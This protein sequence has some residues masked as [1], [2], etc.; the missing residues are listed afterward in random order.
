MAKQTT[1]TM[2]DD[3]DGSEAEH[4]IE[5]GLD[6][7]TFE[8][9]LSSENYAKL[10]ELF[11]PFTSVARF[12]GRPGAKAAR[13]GVKTYGSNQDRQ[14]NQAIR[15]WARDNNVEIA[16]RGRIPAE[17]I[18]AYGNRNK[19]A[20]QVQAETEAKAE[21]AA[22]EAAKPKRKS[23]IRAAKAKVDAAIGDTEVVTE[24]PEQVNGNTVTKLPTDPKSIRGWA[25][26][27]G[28]KVSKQGKIPASVVE[29]FEK[30]H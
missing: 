14:Q 18:D 7:K 4:S 16:E 10:R 9:D 5:F 6:G 26:A 2:V 13:P 15:A 8:I 21:A 17:V 30:E 27:K 22:V 3:L 28:L 1:I 11:E 25:I 23:A 29:A 19:M 24:T 20:M 12:V